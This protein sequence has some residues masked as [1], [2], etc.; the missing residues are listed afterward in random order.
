MKWLGYVH[1]PIAEHHR[2]TVHSRRSISTGQG[3]FNRTTR[4][5]LHQMRWRKPPRQYGLSV[6]AW[7]LSIIVH[8]VFAAAMLLVRPPHYNPPEPEGQD[9]AI[10]VRFI[11]A[12]PPPPPPPPAVP[13]RRQTPVKPRVAHRKPS[14]PSRAPDLAPIAVPAPSRPKVDVQIAQTPPSI[15]EKPQPLPQVQPV[16]KPPASPPKPEAPAIAVPPPQKVVM[17]P[18]K[19]ALPPPKV[20]LQSQT[21]VPSPSVMDQPI[22]IAQAKPVQGAPKLEVQS[23]QVAPVAVQPVQAPPAAEP[24]PQPQIDVGKVLPR[25]QLE[26][27]PAQKIQVETT[28]VVQQT[29]QTVVAA[30]TPET[31]PE[32]M[33]AAPVQAPDVH[34][35]MNAA[36]TPKIDVPP[37]ALQP[38]PQIETAPP[39]RAAVSEVA[40][41]QATSVAPARPSTVAA[42]RPDASWAQ[43]SDR[44]SKNP[45]Q[46]GHG[47]AAQRQAGKGSPNGVPEFIQREPQGNSDVMTRRYH[48][49]D[50]KPTIFDKY[51][52]PDN[53]DALTAWLQKLVDALSFK[54]TFDLGR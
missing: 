50:Y 3:S 17:E 47:K 44:F 43:Q 9:N 34:I 23:D 38:Q 27:A 10:Q 37:S 29:P 51:W 48:G 14:A 7:T 19:M 1:T 45:P 31:P 25:Q 21:S 36:Q 15:D 30:P 46:P 24:Q 26:S 40:P 52:A 4:L 49:L 33:P 20:T 42:P 13:V 12:T 39:V 32:A 2:W 41:A 8:L 53:Q 28:T 6:T 16:P 54:K 11:D 22:Q 35:D 18:S 5:M